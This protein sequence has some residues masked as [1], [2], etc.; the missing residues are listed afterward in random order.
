M[1]SVGKSVYNV[2]SV[3][4]LSF[5][6]IIEEKICD[7]WRWYRVS[8]TTKGPY[9][10]YNKANMDIENGWYRCDSVRIFD[11]SAMIENIVATTVS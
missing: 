9:N 8:W 3:D 6:T 11:P 2:S 7:S 4:K 1:P 5:G 10:T